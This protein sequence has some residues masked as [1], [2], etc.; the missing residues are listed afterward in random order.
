MRAAS[1]PSAVRGH[2]DPVAWRAG[3][4][5]ATIRRSPSP[6]TGSQPIASTVAT[7]G[8]S[9]AMVTVHAGRVGVGE[10]PV[11]GQVQTR[12]AHRPASA[13][14]VLARVRPGRPPRRG[15]RRRG[16]AC[17]A[18]RPA[19]PGRRAGTRS[20]ST[21]SPSVSHGSHDSMPSNVSPSASRSHCSRPHGCSAT[22]RPARGAH[23]VG[24]QQLAAREDLACVEV[25]GRALVGDRELG[26]PV[27]LVAPQVDAH[28][29]VG[30]RRE[31]VDDRASHG[32]L[33][34]VL[35]LVL[36]PVAGV[37]Q[38]GDELVAVAPLARP[39]TIGSTSSTWGP[40]RCTSAR[41]GATTTVG[42]AVRV[43]QAPHR[44]QP[45][46]HRLDAR[47]HPLERQRLP[48]REQV[49]LVGAQERARGRGPGARRRR[50]SAPRRR[51]GGAGSW[52]RG[53]RW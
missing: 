38:R 39:T 11:E 42:R 3:R 51:T 21:C 53:R 19:G 26:E 50:S 6:T 43:A 14:H 29:T 27:D 1:S 15:C 8:P 9:G 47:A 16:R 13:P 41:T 34:A 10:Q 17:A 12:E 23:L 2:D 49:D 22:R 7:S 46:A 20:N 33:A 18:A 36:A 45:A 28:G 52:P 40:S 24:G 35:D 48:R 4:P 44:P 5:A 30:G 31:H 37:H 25:D 32:D